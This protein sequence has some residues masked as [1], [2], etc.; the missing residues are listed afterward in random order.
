M[1]LILTTMIVLGGIELTISSTNQV[2]GSFYLTWEQRYVDDKWTNVSYVIPRQETAGLLLM[3]F[4][5]RKYLPAPVFDDE[6]WI[7]PAGGVHH[8]NEDDPARMYE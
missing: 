7:D 8:G 3:L 4:I 1:G 5:L 2:L 6:M